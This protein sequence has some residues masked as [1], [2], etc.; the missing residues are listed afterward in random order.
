MG[1]TLID[2]R[3]MREKQRNGADIMG[4][5]MLD[6]V[7]GRPWENIRTWTSVGGTDELP[8]PYLFRT[9][10][11]MPLMER[12][13]LELSRGSVLDIGCGAGSH[14][15][16]LQERGL[17]VK[18]I[19]VSAGAI[20]TCRIRGV[21]SAE[22]LDI[23][24]LK[25]EQFDTLL[26]LMNGMGICSRLGK[27]TGLLSHL[28]QLLR[29]GGQILADS[30]DII[31]MYEPMEVDEEEDVELPEL[32][33]EHYYGEVTFQT[34][35]KELEGRPFPWLYVDFHNLELHASAAGLKCERVMQGEHYD[36][37]AR[38]TVRED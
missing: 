30:S 1:P 20:E 14:A 29:P 13:A 34:F 18:A 26:L 11:E 10:E 35:Y 21:A 36:Y 25:G 17:H 3:Q 16:W 12:K 38:L 7:N 27:L 5:A 28:K 24:D 8:L 9:F 37:L 33:G 23:W 22:I 31:Y 32:P 15:L 2:M 4:T 19:D 6:Y